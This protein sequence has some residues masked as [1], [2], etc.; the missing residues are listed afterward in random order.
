MGAPVYSFAVGILPNNEGN[1]R[2]LVQ[3]W[4]KPNEEV[5]LSQ[6][7][8]AHTLTHGNCSTLD[9]VRVSDA[10]DVLCCKHCL[11]RIS[12]PSNLKTLSDLKSFFASG[13]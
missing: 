13:V 7:I 5:V 4:N 1:I 10:K 12:L 8:G 6:P 11:L 2:V 3:E 9:F